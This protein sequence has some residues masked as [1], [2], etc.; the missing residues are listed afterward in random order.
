MFK[1]RFIL[2]TTIASLIFIQVMLW[3]LFWQRNNLPPQAPFNYWAPW[4]QARLAPSFYLWYLPALGTVFLMID[5][6]L[7]RFFY[8]LEKLIAQLLSLTAAIFN[9]LLTLSLLRILNLI[10]HW[11]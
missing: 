8:K 7:A 9:L 6:I 5:L 3:S 11:I 2:F 4:G 1:N 10:F